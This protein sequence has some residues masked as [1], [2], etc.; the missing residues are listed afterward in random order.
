[1]Y[2]KHTYL[3]LLGPHEA[4]GTVAGDAA[5]VMAIEQPG[6]VNALVI[7]LRKLHA[8]FDAGEQLQG[9]QPTAVPA[10]QWVMPTGADSLSSH[11][12]LSVIE[13][14]NEAAMARGKIDSLSSDNRT[15][16]RFIGTRFRPDRLMRDVNGATLAIPAADIAIAVRFARNTGVRA[17]VEGEQAIIYFDNFTLRLTPPWRGAG[18]KQLEFVL[19]HDVPANPV[20]RFGPHSRLRFGPAAV[21][22]WDFES[23]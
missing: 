18:V 11:F 8:I 22:T 2:G 23:Q 21:A 19:T 6:G 9:V 13:F 1:M 15:S 12:Q 4:A 7:R 3:Q 20:Y 5:V 17:V 10:V 16:T 14:S